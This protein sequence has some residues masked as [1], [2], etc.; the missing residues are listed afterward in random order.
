MHNHPTPIVVHRVPFGRTGLF[1]VVVEYSEEDTELYPYPLSKTFITKELHL[2]DDSSFNI[3]LNPILSEVFINKTFKSPYL[4]VARF[5]SIQNSTVVMFFDEAIGDFYKLKKTSHKAIKQIITSIVKGIVHLHLR[6]ILHG[7]VKAANVLIYDGLAKINDFGMSSLIIGQGTQRF[8]Q[9]LYTPT[10][11]PPEMWNIDK[12]DLS[13]DVWALGCTIYE[14]VYGEPLFKVMKTNEEYLSQI[15]SWCDSSNSF[16]TGTIKFHRDWNKSTN[17]DINNLIIKMINPDPSKRPTIFE[18]VKDEYF[19]ST[20]PP[21]YPISSS[22]PL[23]TSNHLRSLSISSVSSISS[24]NSQY[25]SIS[26]V[27]SSFTEPSEIIKQMGEKGRQS[28]SSPC[29]YGALNDCPIVSQRLYNRN[30]FENDNQLMQ[31]YRDL[32]I[33]E[34]DREI[35]M[36]IVCMCESF[37]KDIRSN[38]DLIHVLN[39]IAHLLTHRGIP[40]MLTVTKRVITD[41]LSFSNQINFQYINWDRFYGVERH[42]IY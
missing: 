7:D 10:H 25:N 1:K 3:R 27:S 28:S 15:K 37:P 11:R 34:E 19:C 24:V 38:H 40:Y 5:I 6:R 35:R 9:K 21:T 36:L 22:N 4:N 16:Y 20:P 30:S 23:E 18:I 31:I 42:F 13:A 33:I 8:K 32:K 29:V 26:S 2:E 14:M 41:L 12:C 17:S 39:I